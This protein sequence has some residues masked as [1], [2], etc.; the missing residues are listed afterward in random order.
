M[1]WA[2]KIDN[3]YDSMCGNLKS[4]KKN[5]LQWTQGRLPKKVY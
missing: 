3:L 4:K 5:D 2:Q 1:V